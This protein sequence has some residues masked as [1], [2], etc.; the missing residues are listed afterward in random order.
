VPTLAV[1]PFENRSTRADDAYLA[2]TIS[3]Q[4]STAIAGARGVRLVSARARASDFALTGTVRRSDDALFVSCQ[5]ERRASGRIV[6]RLDVTRP[7]RELAIIPD[8]IV[9]GALG[10]M[11]VQYGGRVARTVN[12]ALF[13]LYARGRY[14]LARRTEVGLARAVSLF[15]QAATVDSTSALGWIGLALALERA[16]R[17]GFDAPGVPRDSILT[18]MVAASERAVELDSLSSDVWL[19]RGLVAEHVDPTTRAA[20]IRAYRRAI[21]VDSLSADAWFR[22]GVALEDSDDPDGA[23]A[24]FRRALAFQPGHLEV[25]GFVALHFYWWRQLDSAAVAADSAIATDPAYLLA[26]TAAGDIALQ[27]GRFDDAEAHF[28]AA[29]RLAT[30]PEVQGYVGLAHVALARGDSARARAWV[31]QAEVRT[32][33]V[34]PSVHGAQYMGRAYALLGDADRALWWLARYRP[35]RDRHYQLHLR[36]E[37]ELD[38]LRSDPRFQAILSRP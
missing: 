19:M 23:L 35:L 7:V 4:V 26:R 3:D 21:A 17:W 5:V 22:L 12:P 24:A 10:A 27:R 13:D 6:W 9:A 25:L 11:G 8:T 14:Q 34:S 2:A 31:A 20:A 28:E 15:R 16:H 32:D 36:H 37:P 18:A 33:S 30:G 1:A 29:G 38:P